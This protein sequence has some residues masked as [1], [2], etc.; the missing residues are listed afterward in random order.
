M[1]NIKQK[2]GLFCGVV[3]AILVSFGY[4]LEP[5]CVWLFGNSVMFTY[6]VSKEEKELSIQMALYCIIAFWGVINLGFLG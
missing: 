6:F 2:I 4:T 5:N 1:K 3:G